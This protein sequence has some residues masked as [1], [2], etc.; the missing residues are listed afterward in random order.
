MKLEL[1]NNATKTAYTMMK[2]HIRSV[3]A[4]QKLASECRTSNLPELNQALGNENRKGDPANTRTRSHNSEQERALIG[5]CHQPRSSRHVGLLAHLG[6]ERHSGPHQDPPTDRLGKISRVDGAI[7][8]N[9]AHHQESLD[10]EHRPKGRYLS[11]G[12]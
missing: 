3:H 1:T 4:N 6:G 7:A 12:E 2:P 10:Q 11:D 9:C 5:N 8:L